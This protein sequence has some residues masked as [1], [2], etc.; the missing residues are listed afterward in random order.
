MGVLDRFERRLEGLVSGAFARAFKSEVQPVEIASALQREMDNHAAI[1][2]PGRTFVPNDFV[3]ELGPA[4]HDRLAVYAEA[5]GAELAAMAREHAA[6]QAY[7]LI[8][9]VQV[10]FERHEDLDTGVFRVRGT[11]MSG[12]APGQR[13]GGQERPRLEGQGATFVLSGPVTV[14]GRGS[15]AH[16]RLDDPGVS[17]RHAEVHLEMGGRTRLVDLGSTNGTTVDGKQVGEVTLRDGVEVV[18]G[19]TRL[20]YRDGDGG[21]R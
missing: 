5:L 12:G 13:Q 2:G 19:R 3:V 14:I 1:V 9:P 20:L 10:K 18:V 16:I 11:A 15:E 6:E 8:G 21:E 17:R 7:T 4:D